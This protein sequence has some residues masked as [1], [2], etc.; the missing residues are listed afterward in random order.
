MLII[1]YVLNGRGDALKIITFIQAKEISISFYHR[2]PLKVEDYGKIAV[3]LACGSDQVN[4]LR[5]RDI[6]C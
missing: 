2:N 6:V 1:L 3:L 4:W 5:I